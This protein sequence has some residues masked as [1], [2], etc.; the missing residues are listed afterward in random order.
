[1]NRSFQRKVVY[2]ALI[3]AL[4]IPLSVIGRPATTS[5]D[6]SA[7]SSGGKLAE[8]RSE[9]KL[10]QAQLGK[11]DPTTSAVRY[12]SLGLHG[13]AVAVLQARA[14]EQQKNEDW[15]SF[16]SSLKQITYLQP[17]YVRVWQEQGWNVAY[18]IS[19]MWD[20]YREKY[21][22][23][24]RGFK[25]LHRGMEY[26]EL[27]PGHPFWLGWYIAHKMGQ[28][29]EYRQF[30]VLFAR[31]VEN[32]K[33]LV[34]TTG[35]VDADWAEEKD[36]WLYAR[37]YLQY[38]HDLVD[39]RGATL[40]KMAA[41]NFYIQVPMTQSKYAEAIE[42]EGVF[43][44]KARAAWKQSELYWA[45]FAARELPSEHG[46]FFRMDG[47]NEYDK[48]L[49][50]AKEKF[51]ALTPGLREKIA[52]EKY[53]ALPADQQ[54]V[55]KVPSKDRK[56]HEQRLAYFADVALAFNEMDIAN[57]AEESNREEAKRAAEEL[58]RRKL[59]ATEARSTRETYKVDYWLTRSEMER[60]D[61]ALTAREL[62]Y[63]AMRDVD[64][65]PW[66]ARKAFEDG[67][68]RWAVII[69]KYPGMVDDQ[70]AIEVTDKIKAYQRVLRQL[71]EPFE[72]SKFVLR[73]LMEKNYM[74]P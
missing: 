60:T 34:P 70:T 61:E 54:A 38:A 35:E 41:E 67:F 2:L 68:N 11:I 4:L 74:G 40:Q 10:G 30:R 20:D 1:M 66:E 5:A 27:E 36:S 47:V 43:G 65:K 56:E 15:I 37:R 8:L 21:Y 48:D 52:A 19:S 33:L 71:D 16:M 72:Q 24:I 73:E 13:V 51:D 12:V 7:E 9:Y 45:A 39:R 64:D 32:R 69:K 25:L 50:R 18:N 57:R 14:S 28:S 6:P 31:D 22:W 29:D 17:Y 62:F 26:N 46:Y 63:Q 59:I 23:V 55:L 42:R 58:M 49:K 53:A 44:E 3:A